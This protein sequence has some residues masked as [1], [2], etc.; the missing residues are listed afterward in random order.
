MIEAMICCRC[1]ELV[2]AEEWEQVQDEFDDCLRMEEPDRV[3]HWVCAETTD[4]EN[5]QDR[6]YD[7]GVVQ[8]GPAN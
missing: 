3:F 5:R 7:T 1:N 6:Y 8:D 4:M 2:T